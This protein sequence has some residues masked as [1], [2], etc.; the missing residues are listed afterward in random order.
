MV[1]GYGFPALANLRL[2]LVCPNRAEFDLGGATTDA[3]GRLLAVAA[4]LPAYPPNPCVL[5][6][7]QGPAALATADLTIRLA[8][9][10]SFSPQNGPPGTM[11]SFTVR[12][13]SLIHI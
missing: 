11:V 12:N 3:A 13:L 2:I 4:A 7:R 1:S 10:L 5:A 6:A 8:L 9:E